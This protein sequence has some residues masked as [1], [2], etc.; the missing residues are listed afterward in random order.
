MAHLTKRIT[1]YNDWINLGEPVVMWISGLHIPESY[2]TALVQ[3]TC[4]RKK[5]PLDKSTLYTAVTKY[6]D[7]KEIKC[8]PEDGC[9]I[10]G[11]YLEGA[12]W[13]HEK[14]I[15]KKQ[16][17]KELIIEMP[18]IQII[19]VEANKLK[20]KN[21]LKTPVYVT[22][23]RKN[24]MGSGQVFEADL[25]TDQHD[26]LWILQGVCLVLNVDF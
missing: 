21:N 19:P 9:Y 6:I 18:V 8:K 1:L 3:T 25:S 13:D 15:L 24:A 10:S 16:N 22:Q 12:G 23:N 4:R 17:P 11:F 7:P 14:N 5:W 20:L 26:S 2:V